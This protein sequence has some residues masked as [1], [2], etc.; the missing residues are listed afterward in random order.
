MGQSQQPDSTNPNT[1]GLA[2]KQ[3]HAGIPEV[4]DYGSTQLPIHATASYNFP[5]LQDAADRFALS[6]L[7]QIYTRI[8]NPTTDAVEQKI[9]ALEGGVGAVMTSSGQSATTLAVLNLAGAGDSVVVSASLY[10]GTQNLFKHTLPRLGIET[11]FV[12]DPDDLHTWKQAIKP[13]TKVLFGEVLGNP[14]ADVLDV[15]A[16]ADIAHQAGLPLIVDSTLTPPP[17]FRPFEHGVDIVVHSATKY[18]GGHAAALG[19]FVVDSG[20]FDWTADPEKFPWFNTPDESYHGVVFGT[21]FGPDGPLGANLS[22]ILRLRTQLL[23]DL[24]SAAS[25]FNAWIVNLGLETLSLRVSRHVESALT[26]AH[27]LED[28]PL[29]Q[30]VAYAGLESSPW[31]HRAQRLLPEGTSGI[32]SFNIAGGAQAGRIFAEALTL[33]KRVANLG[34]TRSLVIHP[35]STTHAQLSEAEQRAAGVEPSLVR[36]SVGL[37]NPEDILADL[38]QGFAAVEQRR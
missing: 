12:D 4:A 5:T 21:D 31:Y 24:G 16:V 15:E 18:L 10:G 28:H 22:Y 17:V 9:A 14:K 27:W 25:P 8:T 32:V 2:T 26:V 13:N 29:V 3:I 19:G 37:E 20:H 11:I 23:R 6:S 38:Q 33:H 34:D 36:L 1:W 30:H 7:G 35:A